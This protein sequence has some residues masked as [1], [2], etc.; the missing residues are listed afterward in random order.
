MRRRIRLLQVED[1]ESDALLIERTLSRSGYEV[2]ALRVETEKQM[3]AALE[4][5]GW[6]LVIADYCLPLFS[7]PAALRVLQESRLDLPFLVVSG[8]MGEDVAVSM[9]KAGAHDYMLKDRMERLS[10]A[11]ERELQDADLRREHREADSKLR[12][13]GS[14][15]ETIYAH[16]P[17]LMFV[18]GDDLCVQKMNVAA[19]QFSG[20]AM[21]HCSGRKVCDLIRCRNDARFLV[22][23]TNADR[24]E[25]CIFRHA[26][27]DTF[28]TGVRHEAVEVWSAADGSTHG[29]EECLLLSIGLMP[30][31][32]RRQALVCAQ[33]VTQLKSTVASLE[34][35]LA[36]KAVLFKEVHHRVK[37]NL[38]IIASLLA[39]KARMKKEQVSINDLKEC[40][41]RVAAMALI[42]EQLYSQ[43]DVNS[44][45]Y[46]D[47]VRQFVPALVAAYDKQDGLT[48]TLDLKPAL[49]TIDQSIPCGLILNEL[50]TNAI[51]YAYPEGEGEIAV[52]LW[53]EDDQVFLQVA[54]KGVGMPPDVLE[55]QGQ[56]LGMQLIPMLSKQLR[57]QVEYAPGPGTTVTIS[58]PRVL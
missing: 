6:D 1:S 46:A 21:E 39:M 8:A 10:P 36:E 25:D 7:A 56:S 14:E 20:V 9:M 13:V 35:A 50:I 26:M 4:E 15:L 57:G 23:K 53:N 34:A 45:D 48:L 22:E 44:I 38:Q 11:V 5:R 16:A 18:I 28:S 40:E 54:D 24:C 42:H 51:K 30:E 12:E 55:H 31:Q 32:E 2:D 29:R 27:L 43:K 58:F 49:L 19:E 17:V 41:H 33:N 37:N 52:R 3:R 47:Y